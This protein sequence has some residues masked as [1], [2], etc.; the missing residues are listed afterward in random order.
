MW[1]SL[2]G[3]FIYIL[4]GW[5][6]WVTR[7]SSCIHAYQIVNVT[8]S[9]RFIIKPS[10]CILTILT[11]TL[12]MNLSPIWNGE[13]ADYRDQYEKIATSFLHG[14]LYF[15][16][17]VNPRLQAMDNPYD[18]NARV[19]Q[20]VHEYHWDHAYYKDHLYMYF[21]VVPAITLF[22]PYLYLT[23]SSLTTY[24][25]TQIYVAFFILGIFLLFHL[26]ARLFFRTLSLLVYLSLSVAFSVI[27][28]VYIVAT[29]AMYCTAQSAA[30]CF[31][32]WG[33]FF[34][35]KAVWDVKTE[36]QT[37]IWA[38]LGA[39]CGALAFGCRPTIAL[40]NIVALPLAIVFFRKQG[41]TIRKLLHFS[42]ILLPYLVIGMALM[43]YNNA[44]FE[45][46][47]EFGQSYQLTIAD[48]SLY[49]KGSSH[50]CW[51]NIWSNLSFCLFAIP[52]N[53]NPV[54]F[55]VFVSYPILWLFVYEIS[56]HNVIIQLIKHHLSGFV[57]ISIIMVLFIIIAIAFFSPFPLP[58][59]RLD[60][61]W[62][63]SITAYIVLGIVYRTE[64]HRN[65]F[66]YLIFVFSLFS[67]LACVRQF[68]YPHDLNF[69]EYYE[70]TV[71]Q[72]VRQVFLPWTGIIA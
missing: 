20:G 64:I 1:Y 17:E 43:W 56:K 14:H 12:P 40:A 67:I 21:G 18:Y 59:Y 54:L 19:E 7:P 15:E 49:G 16:E 9:K 26:L 53:L 4:L 57:F 29:P 28:V 13:I 71:P 11:C 61:M 50:L 60:F 25:A 68:F 6:L 39:I 37:I 30:L 55:G 72:I 23:G 45:N 27:S 52:S 51:N 65:R 58:R 36:N 48:Q 42:I 33:L 10:V 22:V 24:H 47:L 63:L 46:P 3:V 2:L 8:T 66:S 38:S 69:S 35:V 31:M 70:D 41:L 5:A 34:Y 32:L 44:R 62:L